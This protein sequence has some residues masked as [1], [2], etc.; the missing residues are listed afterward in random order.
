[1]M[2]QHETK[3]HERTCVGCGKTA[4]P[5]AL[6]RLVLASRGHGGSVVVDAAGGAFGRGAHVHASPDCIQRAARGG[7]SR[8]FRTDVKT[9]A[10]ALGAAIREAYERRAV[11][12][13]LGARRAG[14]LALGADAAQEALAAGA[15]LV[16]VATDAGAIVKRFE[17]A[18]AEGRGASFGT[19]AGLGE[20]FGT[21]ETAVFAVRHQGVATSLRD[22]LLVA[23]CGSGD[24]AG[25]G[26]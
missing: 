6:V 18:V 21:G 22:A 15:P 23:A 9:D 16:V 7:L 11:G 25:E 2:T 26:R 1:M 13:L 14:H 3:K 12:L 10:A 19:K 20:L 5:A 8:A 17:R 4:A 24:G